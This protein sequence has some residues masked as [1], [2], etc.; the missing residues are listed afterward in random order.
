MIDLPPISITQLDQIIEIMSDEDK[1]YYCEF[2]MVHLSYI[3]QNL[4]E[5]M[6]TKEKMSFDEFM[7]NAVTCYT[8][9][10][11]NKRRAASCQDIPMIPNMNVLGPINQ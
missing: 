8:M 5:V 7:N 3:M 10:L 4:I 2:R 9:N 6:R 11:I 1:K